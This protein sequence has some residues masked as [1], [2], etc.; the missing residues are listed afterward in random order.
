[1]AGEVCNRI[2]INTLMQKRRDEEVAKCVQ[3]IGFRQTDFRKQGFQMLA[4]RV[5]MDGRAVV[6][7]ENVFREW[8]IGW[9]TD[10]SRSRMERC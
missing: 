10:R 8:D 5:R 4:E 1:M 3:V 7:R 6:F 9:R 2:F